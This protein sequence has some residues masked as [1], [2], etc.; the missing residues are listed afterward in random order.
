MYRKHNIDDMYSLVTHWIRPE[1]ALKTIFIETKK[2][3]FPQ[4]N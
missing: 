2:L 3:S 4:K 1:E